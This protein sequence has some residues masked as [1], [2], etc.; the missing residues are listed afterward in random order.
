MQVDGFRDVHESL[1]AATAAAE[2]ETVSGDTSLK[3]GQEVKL[4]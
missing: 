3:S 4:C 1:E 2:I